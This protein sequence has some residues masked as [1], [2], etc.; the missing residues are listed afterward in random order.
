M[1][2][3]LNPILSH[4]GIKINELITLSDLPPPSERRFSLSPEKTRWLLVDH[5]ALQGELG[6]LYSGRVVGCIDHHDEE[7][8]V[9]KDCGLEPRI[10][11]KSG[12]CASLIIE[13]CKDAWSRLAHV[14]ETKTYDSAWARMALAP[15]LIDTTNLKNEHKVTS[16]DLMAAKFLK[17]IIE[18]S[19]PESCSQD[20]YFAQ[21]S[22]AKEAIDGL[23]LNDILR[24]DY[25]QWTEG[26]DI[27]LGICSTVKDMNYLLRKAGSEDLFWEEIQNFATEETRRLS[28]C[29]IMTA[30]T[31]DGKFGRELLLLGLDEAGIKAVKNFE[32]KATEELGL[33]PWESGRLDKTDSESQWSRCWVQTGLDKSRK[34]VGPILRKAIA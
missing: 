21:I 34:Q 25:K 7:S 29:A 24:K 1:R 9:P 32:K 4:A 3:E 23:C 15:I 30:F 2:P 16:H 5:N 8:K 28:I 17:H 19:S 27:N 11:E 20:D 22:K 31:R 33:Q 26:Q 14:E 6:Q 10:I 13:H 18:S 12:S